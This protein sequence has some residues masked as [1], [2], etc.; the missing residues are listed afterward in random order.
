[1]KTFVARLCLL[2]VSAALFPP[3][4]VCAQQTNVVD[5]AVAS[6]AVGL[7][8][9]ATWPPYLVQTSSNLLDWCDQGELLNGTATGTLASARAQADYRVRHLNASNHLAEFFGLLQTE[10]GEGGALLGRHRLKSRWWLYRPQGAIA[11]YPAAFFGQLIAFYQRVEDGNVATFAGRLDSLGAMATPGDAD[12]LTIAWTNGAGT[13]ERSYLL[14]LDFPYAVN[15]VLGRE[16]LPS[17]PYWQLQCSY[18][19]PQPELDLVELAMG[20]TTTDL[21]SLVELTPADTNDYQTRVRDYSV[22]AGGMTA[23]LAY[24]EGLPLWEGRPP[25]VFQTYMLDCWTAPTR[26]SGGG[27]PDF[28][29]DSYF[30]RTLLATHHNFV[31]SAL[32]EPALDPALGEAVRAALAAAN[33]RYV[34]TQHPFYEGAGSE[35]IRLIG[36]DH[37]IR[38]P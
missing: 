16:P 20:T 38:H 13:N 17:D 15:A 25:L 5:F 33:V 35:D 23:T 3:G 31:E 7:A 9:E 34:Y 21:I 24:W 28:G 8:W 10:Q 12:I 32:I 29:T 6:N 26:V 37:K 27:L 36:F 22:V 4:T 14:T 30:A 11:E 1:M 19:S 2:S 18:A